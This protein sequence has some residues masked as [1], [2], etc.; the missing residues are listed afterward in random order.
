MAKSKSDFRYGTKRY[1]IAALHDAGH[2]RREAFNE[3]RPLVES[4][5]SPM[6]FSANVGGGRQA[7]PLHTQLIDLKNEIGRVFALCGSEDNENFRD[8]E[9]HDMDTPQD[10]RENEDEEIREDE[11]EEENEENET[12]T[13]PVAKGKQ[14]VSE[15]L[16]FFL[17]EIRRLRRWCNERAERGDQID[18]ISMRPAQ[19]A[20][21]LI[22]D[23]IPAKA[24]LYAMTMHWDSD[25][26]ANAGIESFDFLTIS[27]DMGKGFHKLCGYVLKLANARQPIMLVGPAGSGKS[28]IARQIAE[29]L[30]LPYGETPMSPGATRGDM[31]GRWTIKD[32]ISSEFV[33]IYSGGGVF[34][35]EEIDS[36]DPSMLIVLNNALAADRLYNSSDGKMYEKHPDFIPVST[37]N[38]FGTG[39]T[40]EYS[41]RERLDGATLDRWR[42]GRVFVP[43]DERVEEDLLFS[44]I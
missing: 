28:H 4:Q 42:M 35:F 34:N 44:R 11:D 21:R 40:R 10:I 22:P 2:S 30:G 43:I 37:A 7:K 19:A 29:I 17:R 39:A 33:R 31:L 13:P 15:E 36:A 20:A 5:I 3:L 14:R 6:I 12:H 26:R 18:S 41:A 24:L 38:T 16:N 8:M 32:F 9:I 1:M 25:A 27:E 23:G